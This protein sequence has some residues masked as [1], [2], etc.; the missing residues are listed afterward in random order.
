M[1]L[2]RWPWKGRGVGRVLFDD[3]WFQTAIE[4]AKGGY[5][6]ACSMLSWGSVSIRHAMMILIMRSL[7]SPCCNEPRPVAGTGPSR[8]RWLLRHSQESSRV[9]LPCARWSRS[10]DDWCRSNWRTE[11]SRGRMARQ[12]GYC[13]VLVKPS[14]GH[15]RRAFAYT[16]VFKPNVSRCSKLVGCGNWLR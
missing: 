11:C 16:I 6:A 12:Q 13:L 4:L 15:D 5:H 9:L 2:V 3:V 8:P 10:W 1:G 7:P 14:P